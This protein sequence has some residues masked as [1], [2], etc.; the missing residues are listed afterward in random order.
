MGRS[1]GLVDVARIAGVSHMTVSR[2]LNGHPSVKEETR[3]RVLAAVEQ[4]GYRRNSI[5]RALHGDL[6]GTIGVVLAGEEL[7]ELSKVLRGVE[8]AARSAGYWVNLA[9][10]HGGTPEELAETFNRLIDQSVEG[11]ALIADRPL[12]ADALHR[13]QARVP[14]AVVMSGEVDNERLG[15]VEI[16]QVAGARMLTTHLLQL[17]HRRIAHLSGPARVY[18]ARARVRGWQEELARAGVR[19]TTPLEGDFTADSGYELTRRLLTRARMPS[20]IFAGNDHMAIGV[21]AALHEAGVRVPDDVSLV[22]FDDAPAVTHL[23]PPLTTVRQDF[24][25]LGA[26]VVEVLMAMLGGGTP[27]HRRLT[28]QLIERSSTAH[29]PLP[30]PDRAVR[31]RETHHA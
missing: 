12:A 9:A 26:S 20:A 17:G 3:A 6:S 27:E 25:S 10:W 23:V 31:L 28:P 1:P 29:P 30:Q 16:D 21:L 7:H 13:V 18:D 15:S 22:G 5:A 4:T 2:V 11:I 14:V 8:S 19:R 24:T